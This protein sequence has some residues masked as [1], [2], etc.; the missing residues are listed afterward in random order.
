LPLRG[1]AFTSADDEKL[2]F[3]PI[4]LF[5]EPVA[6]VATDQAAVTL[7][8]RLLPGLGCCRVA[9]P[10]VEC[11]SAGSAGSAGRSQCLLALHGGCRALAIDSG[12]S[13]HPSH[14]RR[15]AFG[16]YETAGVQLLGLAATAGAVAWQER[17]LGD[18]TR[19]KFERGLE[20]IE[21]EV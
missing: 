10:V 17:A 12:A 6:I 19:A 18:A 7:G 14:R 11:R 21:T 8:L 1:I 5:A 9:Q 15:C 4:R 20:R 16:G 13:G 2:H 3:Y